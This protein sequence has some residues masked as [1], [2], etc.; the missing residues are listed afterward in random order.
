MA[1]DTSILVIV[2]GGP[3][4]FAHATPALAAIRR[5]RRGER[6]ILLTEPDFCELAE[7]SPYCDIAIST[8]KWDTP[9]GLHQLAN[10]L[11]KEKI[12]MIF[13]LSGA[14]QVERLLAAMKPN[15]PPYAST[16]RG[17][18]F[19]SDFLAVSEMHPIDAAIARVAPA[20]I[21]VDP[22]ATPDVSWAA[23]ARRNAP[24]LKPQYFG[25]RNPYVVIVPG[26][27]DGADGP[28]WPVSQFAALAM[29]L[30]ERGVGVAISADPTNRDAARAVVRACPRA[31][32]LAGR[33]SYTQLCSVAVQAAGALG[34]AESDLL[35]LIA[36]AGTPTVALTRS[37]EEAAKA[38]RGRAVAALAVNNR[39]AL[40]AEYAAE[41]L[42]M[43]ARVDL[44]R[45]SA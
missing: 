5:A 45:A 30:V 26:T 23:T 18:T 16:L 11:R 13:D 2:L 29:Q 3:G 40:T 31:R 27:Q 22:D 39:D 10:A 12:S 43:F 36:A 25:L 14:M 1:S 6:L 34:H 20:G 17:A 35:H 19:S 33:A 8:D 42:G 7:D 15:P 41:A 21:I 37:H 9:R 4:G 38:P 32:D 24:S 28:I 44:L